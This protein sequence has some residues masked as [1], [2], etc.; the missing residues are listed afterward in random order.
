M[1][2]FVAAS[3]FF[4][5]ALS[6][7]VLS[8][9]LSVHQSLK[10]T[11]RITEQLITFLALTSYSL[12]EALNMKY[13][14]LRDA[15]TSEEEMKIAVQSDKILYEAWKRFIATKAFPTYPLKHINLLPTF[16]WDGALH[17]LDNIYYNKPEPKDKGEHTHE[18][19]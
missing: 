4:G 18:Q 19:D 9:F 17:P 5:G 1:N 16:D 14:A 8:H 15:G 6:F 2:I 13:D 3:L 7:M 11:E 10:M 12:A